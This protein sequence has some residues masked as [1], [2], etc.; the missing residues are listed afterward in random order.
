MS[1]KCEELI[2]MLMINIYWFSGIYDQLFKIDRVSDL[3]F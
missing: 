1:N 3:K 2:S